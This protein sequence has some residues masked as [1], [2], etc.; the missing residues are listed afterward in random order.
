M[1]AQ[2]TFFNTYL[3]A[4]KSMRTD[5]HAQRMELFSHSLLGGANHTTFVKQ[6]ASEMKILF[7]SSNFNSVDHI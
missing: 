3:S 6:M 7:R 4:L 5:K 2:T 1:D